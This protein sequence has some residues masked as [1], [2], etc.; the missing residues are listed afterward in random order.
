MAALAS[1]GVHNN[2][3]SGK[4]GMTMGS[5]DHKFSG[6]IDMVCYLAGEQSLQL[7]FQLCLYPWDKNMNHILLDL[8]QHGKFIIVKII[9]LGGNHNGIDPDRLLLVIIL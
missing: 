2:L 4:S 1:I 7:R 9:M 5:S 3:S 8:F 6:R